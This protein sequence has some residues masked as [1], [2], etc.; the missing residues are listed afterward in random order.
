MNELS[1]FKKIQVE[2]YSK[3]ADSF[4]K[5]QKRENRN[6]INKINAIRDFFNIQRKDRVLE[7]GVGT[8]IHAYHLLKSAPKDVSYYGIDLSESMLEQSKKRLSEFK[9]VK[10]L[11]MEGENLKFK[12]N[13]FDKVFISGSL[14]HFEIPQKGISEMIRVLKKGG[15]FCI[16]EPNYMFPTNFIS[17]IVLPEEKNISLMKKRLFKKWLNHKNVSYN[18][19]N[20]AYT[21]PF[22]KIFIPFY[23]ILDKIIAKIPVINKISVMLFVKGIKNE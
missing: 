11:S 13:F 21:P 19:E 14:H 22:P 18:I 1:N 4:D 15:R 3:L 17:S 12:N 8:G 23:N 9:N 2:T 10:L 20:F 16:M 7:L 6:H 5:K